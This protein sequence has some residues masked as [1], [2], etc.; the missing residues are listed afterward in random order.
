MDRNIRKFLEKK[1]RMPMEYYRKI[2]DKGF[3][4]GSIIFGGW[5]ERKSDIDVVLPVG[6]EPDFNELLSYGYYGG[7]S[8]EDYSDLLY[9]SLY[10]LSPRTDII[11]NLLFIEEE[12]VYDNWVWSTN[13]LCD[14]IHSNTEIK[15]L[16]KNKKNRVL[17]FETLKKIWKKIWEDIPY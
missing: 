12:W 8:Y 9:K 16:M 10:V 2:R 1:E 14:F 6:F 3:T 13:M 11:Y 4:T 15:S 5:D 7:E 17:M